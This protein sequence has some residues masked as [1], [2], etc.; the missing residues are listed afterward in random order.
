MYPFSQ[1]YMYQL[2]NLFDL[3][4]ATI[5]GFDITYNMAR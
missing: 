3:Q 2:K 4:I 5:G 1:L